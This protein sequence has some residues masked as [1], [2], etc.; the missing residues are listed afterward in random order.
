MYFR[1]RAGHCTHSLGRIQT[2]VSLSNCPMIPLFVCR[3]F[4]KRMLCNEVET[5]VQQSLISQAFCDSIR[6]TSRNPSTLKGQRSM[7]LSSLLIDKT[8][9][10]ER[11]RFNPSGYVRAHRSVLFQLRIIFVI[12]REGIAQVR[13]MICFQIPEQAEQG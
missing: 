13:E 8:S 10:P 7:T 11:L 4:A 6:S 5:C 3:V 2:V 1:H 9:P 12:H